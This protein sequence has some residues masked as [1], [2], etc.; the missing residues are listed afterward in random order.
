MSKQTSSYCCQLLEVFLER[1]FKDASARPL[2]NQ[3]IPPASYVFS[4]RSK[5]NTFAPGDRLL[6][7]S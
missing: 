6:G 4:D 3:L 7:F 5:V 1:S 2:K